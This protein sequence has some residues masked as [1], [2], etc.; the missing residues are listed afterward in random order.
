[1]G[2]TERKE[3]EKQARINLIKK[4][5]RIMFQKKGFEA[6][7]M[8]EIAEHA[9]ISKATIYKYFKS[10]DDLFYEMMQ[11][12]L[13][14]LY[15][16]L[17]EIRTRQKDPEKTIKLIIEETYNFYRKYSDIYHLVTG[18][19]S[20]EIKK[21]LPADKAGNLKVI[22]AS[23]LKQLELTL[24]DGIEKRIFRRIE[25][26]VGAVILWN[27][28]MGIVKYQENR[29]DVGKKDYRKSTLDAGVDLLLWGLKKR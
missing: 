26:M 11:E 15:K 13:T 24:K 2:I 18:L 6:A 7:K 5:A 3:R 27:M 25:P 12:H 22:M 14:K 4:S 20:S 8:E 1:M 21:L 29:L 9:E 23:N 16:D 10:K 28:F 17:V 19:K